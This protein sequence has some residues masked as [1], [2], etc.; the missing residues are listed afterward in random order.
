MV[1]VRVNIGAETFH[2]RNMTDDIAMDN[3]CRVNILETTL[4]QSQILSVS[5]L[6]RSYQDLIQEILDKTFL[7][8]S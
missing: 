4:L 8:R 2:K 1:S 3:A 6:R 5:R 7:Q